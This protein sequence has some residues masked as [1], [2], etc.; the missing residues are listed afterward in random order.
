MSEQEPIPTAEEIKQ[1]NPMTFNKLAES[2]I[3]DALKE[4]PPTELTTT[5][6]II[7]QGMITISSFTPDEQTVLTAHFGLDH[8]DNQGKKLQQLA[9]ELNKD[10]SEIQTALDSAMGK[11]RQAVAEAL[12]D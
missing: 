7:V 11:L 4:N 8:P 3:A 2:I 10:I 6:Q 12:D 5:I 9:L 1:A